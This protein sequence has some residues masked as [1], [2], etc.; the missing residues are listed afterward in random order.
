MFWILVLS[1]LILSITAAYRGINLFNWTL[2]MVLVLAGFAVFTNVSILA[3]VIL[4]V[5]FAVVAVPLN[6]KPFRRHRLSAPFLAIYRKMLPTLSDTEKVALEA[7]TV[8][9]EGELFAGIIDLMTMKFRVFHEDSQGIT[10]ASR[11]CFMTWARSGSP[12]AS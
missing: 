7:G 3:V 12:T 2:G 9:W 6:F 1:L 10:F 11:R 4:S 8:G 5:L